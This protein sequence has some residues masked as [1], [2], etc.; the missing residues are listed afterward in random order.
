MKPRNPSQ[1]TRGRFAPFGTVSSCVV[2]LGRFDG[3]APVKRAVRLSLGS[4]GCES[5]QLL[6][7]KTGRRKARADDAQARTHCDDKQLSSQQT[8]RSTRKFRSEPGEIEADLTRL[9]TGAY[10]YRREPLAQRG[11]TYPL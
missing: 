8:R 7:P 3:R 11:Y 1:K 4:H 9:R 6:S 2:V 5:K 10:A